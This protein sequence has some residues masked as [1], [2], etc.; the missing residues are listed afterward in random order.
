[1]EIKKY[2]HTEYIDF[3]LRYD[4]KYGIELSLNIFL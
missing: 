1:M 4:L 3:D 2:D